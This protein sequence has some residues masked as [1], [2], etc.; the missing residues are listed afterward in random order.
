MGTVRMFL[1]VAAKRGWEVLQMDVYNAFLHIYLDEE[2]YMQL[3]PG[4]QSKDKNKV[5]HLRKSLYGLKH[6]PR[7]WFSKLSKALKDYGLKQ[8]RSDY[9]LFTYEK[10]AIR[11]HILIYV[12]DLIN[13]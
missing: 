6:A 10:G 9:S 13:G 4:F 8:S 3:P 2:G 5:C 11:S 7:C 1:D 12:D